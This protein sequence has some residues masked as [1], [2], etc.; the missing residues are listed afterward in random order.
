[1]NICIPV[2]EDKGLDSQVCE[3][4]GSAP[5]FLIV[6][7]ESGSCRAV[8]N[9]NH[10][11]AH[12]MCQ[13]LMA[14]AGEDVNGVVVGGIG[15]GAVMKL[16]AAGIEV[17]KSAFGTVRETVDAYN[18]G[19]LPKVTPQTACGGHGHGGGCGGHQ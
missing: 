16:T 13:P 3:H 15:M 10:Q 18:A 9:T 8:P 4:F 2:N 1:M 19:R 7:T 5:T 12:G 17:L 6:D 14:L 11:H